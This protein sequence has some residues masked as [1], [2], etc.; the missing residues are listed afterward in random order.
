MLFWCSVAVLKRIPPWLKFIAV[1]TSDSR[2][3]QHE[4]S[5]HGVCG[6]FR[7]DVIV[8]F[9]WTVLMAYIC[10]IHSDQ[11]FR[12]LY[13]GRALVMRSSQ[14]GVR[15]EDSA[16]AVTQSLPFGRRA[17]VFSFNMVIISPHG[18]SRASW[19]T[20]ILLNDTSSPQS[21][22]EFWSIF[23]RHLLPPSLSNI[24]A[25]PLAATSKKDSPLTSKS[26]RDS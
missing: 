10:S 25:I 16:L 20:K 2:N 5:N 26:S 21:S 1:R 19:E 6:G 15:I 24:D 8:E 7:E 3:S 11:R 18:S 22:Q 23:F 12:A 9:I 4:R 13:A 17:Q 14:S